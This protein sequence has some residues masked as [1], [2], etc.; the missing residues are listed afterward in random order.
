MQRDAEAKV[1][2]QA[3]I[4]PSRTASLDPFQTQTDN[5][6]KRIDRMKLLKYQEANRVMELTKKQLDNT[7]QRVQKQRDVTFQEHLDELQHGL[8]SQD[9]ILAQV[10]GT[11]EQAAAVKLEKKAQLYSEWDQE[12]LLLLLYTSHTAVPAGDVQSML[13]AIAFASCVTAGHSVSWRAWAECILYMPADSNKADMLYLIA[14]TDY[15]RFQHSC[16]QQDQTR[17]CQMLHH[18]ILMSMQCSIT[19]PPLTA[20]QL[21]EQGNQQ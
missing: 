4:P 17:A 14:H 1:E 6:Q 21:E 18:S 11:L 2:A 13:H 16:R 19:L 10:N 15:E 20:Q 5:I 8:T 7:M 9:G 3:S 12:V